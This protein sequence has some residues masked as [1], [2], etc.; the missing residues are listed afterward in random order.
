VLRAWTRLSGLGLL[1]LAARWLA[2]RFAPGKLQAPGVALIPLALALT[3]TGLVAA[4]LVQWIW[5]AGGLQGRLL[6]PAISALAVLLMAG[7]TSLVPGRWAPAMAALPALGLAALAIATPL[8]TIA[9]AYAR[10]VVLAT[11]ELPPGV[12]PL[13]LTYAERVKLIG[14]RLDPPVARPGERLDVTLYWQ[15]LQPISQDFSAYIHLFGR[16]R[17][18]I[19]TI[20]TYPGLGS[21]PTSQWQAGQVVEDVYP[22]RIAPD[23]AAPA[24]VTVSVG[25][26]DFHGSREGIHALDS[27]GRPTTEAG[28]FK[29]VPRTWP[30]PGS[31]QAATANLGNVISLVGYELSPAAASLTVTLFWRCDAPPGDEYTVFAHVID[32]DGD[33]VAQM[34]RPPLN[35]DYPT[36]AWEPGEVIRDELAVPLPSPESVKDELRVRVGLYR[37]GDG[38]RLSVLDASGQIAGDSVTL[39][40]AVSQEDLK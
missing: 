35:G 21:Y 1:V 8:A 19:A 25:W 39:P 7:W 11:R 36:S 29:L 12:I 24:L 6:F 38:T 14:Y 4:L 30:D 16:N 9:P 23:A 5:V 32:D 28:R 13:D 2:H 20:D 22:L 18:R 27:L 17:Q 37:S 34:D 40:S 26:Y 10:P 3:W 31:A 15:A 33:V